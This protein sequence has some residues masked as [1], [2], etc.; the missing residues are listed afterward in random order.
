MALGALFYPKGTDENPIKFDNLFI[1]YIYKE[2]YIEGLYIDILNTKK[3]MTIMDLGANL[4]IVTQ[5]MLNNAKKIY[6]IE[7]STEHFEAL[8][9]NKEYNNWD[10]VETFNVAFA[11]KDGEMQLNYLPANRTSH[12]L[13][14]DYK[15]GGQTVKTVA[16]DTFFEQNKIE[17]IDFIKSDVEGAEDLI[18]RSEGFLKVAPKIDAIM[19]EMHYPTFPKLVEHMMSL[20]YKAKR[21]DS[22]AVVIL[23][24]R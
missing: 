1:P 7:P 5:Y 11:D 23:F 18:Y 19:M 14:N 21:Y 10:N 13:V 12:S 6:A 22:S 2:I 4:G 15:Q 9:K 20:G 8:Q 17:H 16:F 24:Y 3:D